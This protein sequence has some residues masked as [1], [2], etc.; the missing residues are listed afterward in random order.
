MFGNA[1]ISFSLTC[2]ICEEILWYLMVKI[3]KQTFSS[4]KYVFNIYASYNFYILVAH[5]ISISDK[6]M[7]SIIRQSS[8]WNFFDKKINA[9]IFIR[10]NCEFRVY[11]A[12][13]VYMHSTNECLLFHQSIHSHPSWR[14]LIHFINHIIGQLTN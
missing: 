3:L 5:S 13:V 6:F 8:E 1:L 14:Q 11:R 2:W 12:S 7:L 4:S 10:Q 9:D